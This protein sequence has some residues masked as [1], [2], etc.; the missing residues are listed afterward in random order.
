[1]RECLTISRI[2]EE[3]EYL[4]LEEVVRPDFYTIVDEEDRY[5]ARKIYLTKFET[6][7]N[8]L[9]EIEKMKPKLGALTETNISERSETEFK[10]CVDFDTYIF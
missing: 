5:I 4:L 7:L 1:M 9:T 2:I 10:K 3:L 6:N 8:I